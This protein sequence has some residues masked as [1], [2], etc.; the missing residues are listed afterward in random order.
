LPATQTWPTV[1]T[2][3]HEGFRS[4]GETNRDTYTTSWNLASGGAPTGGAGPGPSHVVLVVGGEQQV[5]LAA[6]A[7]WTSGHATLVAANALDDAAAAPTITL[8]LPYGVAARVRVGDVLL[9]GDRSL[10]ADAMVPAGADPRARAIEIASAIAAGRPPPRAA[11]HRTAPSSALQLAD[12]DDAPAT[13]LPSRER[14]ILAAVRV[15]AAVEY[16]HGVGRLNHGWE[17]ELRKVLP[18]LDAVTQAQAYVD[19]LN[20]ML[21]ALHDGHTGVYNQDERARRASTAI[22][23]RRID[24]KVAAGGF[25]DEAAARQAGIALGDELVGV[26]GV[27]VEQAIASLRRITSSGTEE[28]LQQWA[29]AIVDRGARGTS[30]ELDVRSASGKLR[31]VALRRDY[32]YDNNFWAHQG[33]HFR[34]LPDQIGYAD[35]TRLTSDEVDAM[36]EALAQ[37]RAIVFDMRGYPGGTAWLIGAR[38]NTRQT[39]VLSEIRTPIV[40]ARASSGQITKRILQPAPATDKPLYRGKIIVLIDDRAVSAAE[41]LCLIFEAT[42]GAKFV[43]SPTNGTNGEETYVRLPGGVEARF[44]GM[45]ILHADG[46]QLQQIGIQPDV[47]VRPTLRGLRAGQDEVLDRAILYVQR[48]R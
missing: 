44:T 8:A 19:E 46:R 2:I 43:G 48:G 47:A 12:D 20:A 17:Q 34:V 42:G 39:H 21:A 10:A 41:H 28:A 40:T 30:V 25:R 13:G 4:Q 14:R 23:W 35:L 37:T 38:I 45:E 24:G 36:F 7:L 18:R 33:P 9:P 32:G 3:R 27:A 31:R 15:W 6:V 5:P 1:R 22:Y 29:A 16:F 26:D 11:V